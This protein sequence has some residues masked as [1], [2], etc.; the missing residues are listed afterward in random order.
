MP[1]APVEAEALRSRIVAPENEYSVTSGAVGYDLGARASCPH[2]PPLP[3][4]PHLSSGPGRSWLSLRAARPHA[5]KMPALPG[6]S[7]MIA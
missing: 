3:S 6:L 4:R 2:L 7:I 5:G 1:Q